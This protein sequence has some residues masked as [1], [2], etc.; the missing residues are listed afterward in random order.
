MGD[1]LHM[2]IVHVIN[3][4]QPKLGYQS[5]YLAKKQKELGHEVSVVTS[6]RYSVFCTDYS[7]VIKPV[8]GERIVG[9][10]EKEEEGVPVIRLPLRFEFNTRILFKGLK[11]TLECLRP[12]AVH[13]HEVT[14]SYSVEVARYKDKLDYSL[15]YDCH[16]AKQHF[17]P[18][19]PA[20]RIHYFFYKS[21][22]MGKIIQK[23]DA[24]VGVHPDAE[25]ILKKF[26]NVNPEKTSMI[27]LGADAD[28]FRFDERE[29]ERKRKELGFEED[30]VVLMT[31]GK[32]IPLKDIHVVLEAISLIENEKIKFL[33]LGEGP[34]DYMKKLNGICRRNRIEDRVLF[35]GMVHRTELPAYFSAA[36]IGVWAGQNSISIQ[37]A[38][39]SSLPVIVHEGLIVSHLISCGGV[40]AF[41]RGDVGEIKECIQ[42]LAEDEN[43]RKDFGKRA[44]KIVEEKFNYDVIAREFLELYGG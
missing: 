36:D 18:V 30:D 19:D 23:G 43:Y 10:G 39:S 2:K 28:L 15:V 38:M 25:H 1:I 7:E 27:P 33:I 16:L 42:R 26:F 17:N 37:E 6:D 12:D 14:N 31:S 24:F 9:V 5:Y 4:F 11:K 20:R 21:F 32:T 29:R 8:L 44:R 13:C 34:A 22:F 35:Q 41:K 40:L 3:Y